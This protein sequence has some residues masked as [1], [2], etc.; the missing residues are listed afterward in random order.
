L[1]DALAGAAT[2]KELTLKYSRDRE[3]MSYPI[4][5][6]LENMFLSSMHLNRSKIKMK[7][8]IRIVRTNLKFSNR[9]V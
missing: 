9:Y 1:L 3:R 5:K 4:R 8:D 7:V 2:H 6:Q